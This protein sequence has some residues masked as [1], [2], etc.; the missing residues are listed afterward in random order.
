M[1]FACVYAVRFDLGISQF[2]YSQYDW[3]RQFIYFKKISV[4]NLSIDLLL[5][6][7]HDASLFNLSKLQHDRQQCKSTTPDD[8]I[9]NFRDISGRGLDC[10]PPPSTK[11]EEHI[12]GQSRRLLMRK[13]GREKCIQFL[14]LFKIYSNLKSVFL[15]QG[16]GG[17]KFFCKFPPPHPVSF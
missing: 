17:S 4:N 5:S 15:R 11:G 13:E 12:I 8:I 3:A 7:S 16:G 6:N 2:Q 1:F 14:W 9:S 10:P